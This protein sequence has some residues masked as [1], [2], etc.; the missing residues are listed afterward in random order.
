MTKTEF[1]CD[2]CKKTFQRERT[3]LSHTCTLKTRWDVKDY[4]A[5]RTGMW[6][7]QQFYRICY[8]KSKEKTIT[9]FINSSYYTDFVKL[10]RFLST[11]KIDCKQQYLH[12]CV[13]NHVKLKDWYSIKTFNRFILEYLESEN[14]IDAI[15]RSIENLV[16]W[17]R[18]TG[19]PFYNFFRDVDLGTGI[20]YIQMGRISPWLLYLSESAQSFTFEAVP[21][22][23]MSLIYPLVNPSKWQT[24]ILCN[25]ELV[26]DTMQLLEDYG[27]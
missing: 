16:K 21:D 14:I 23:Q 9:D 1:Q 26:A 12:W 10:G 20:W 19:R 15:T 22:D 3:L 8:P 18:S 5:Q 7:Y 11:Y 27:L 24:R 25:E 13:K 2:Y 6:A 4:P 17:E